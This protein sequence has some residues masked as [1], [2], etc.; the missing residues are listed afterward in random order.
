MLVKRITDTYVKAST[1]G[2]NKST[3]DL[4]IKAFR[5]ATDRLSMNKEE[6]G[7][8]ACETFASDLKKSLPRIPVITD[9]T[10]WMNFYH[11]GKMLA[12]L[13]LEYES[14]EPCEVTVNDTYTG[15]DEYEHYAV[16][17]M[18]FPKKGEQ[19]TIIYNE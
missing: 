13:H 15:D 8:V 16:S 4:Y 10:E 6:G 12:A 9:E 14:V 7:V 19:G 17:K 3:Y 18:R 5:W 2:L 11:A 1:A